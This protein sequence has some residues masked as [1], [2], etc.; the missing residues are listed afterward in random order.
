MSHWFYLN[1]LTLTHVSGMTIQLRQG[2]WVAPRGIDMKCAAE[3]SGDESARI[4]KAGLAYAQTNPYV[5][6]KRDHAL[7]A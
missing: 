4:I 7:S 6:V 2:S 1:S 5:P 3:I